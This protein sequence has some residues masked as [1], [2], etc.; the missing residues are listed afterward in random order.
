MIKL[1]NISV[2]ESL[3]GKA[4][5]SM[6]LVSQMSVF[7]SVQD[8]KNF[9]RTTGLVDD[10]RECLQEPRID[11]HSDKFSGPLTF[12]ALDLCTWIEDGTSITV[13]DLA[14]ALYG[15]IGDEVEAALSAN[16]DDTDSYRWI[17]DNVAQQLMSIAGLEHGFR[18]DEGDYVEEEGFMPVFK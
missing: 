3:Q 16:G 2:F 15:E 11:V 12:A 14:S 10:I 5:S 6:G 1:A 13:S 4:N 8:A 18:I 9:L 7:N 17:K